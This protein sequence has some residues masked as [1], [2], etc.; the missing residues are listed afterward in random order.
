MPTADAAERRGV[1]RF[2]FTQGAHHGQ[3]DIHPE[4]PHRD[5]Q[6]RRKGFRTSA[7]NAKDPELKELFRKRAEDCARG[8]LGTAIAG[9]RHW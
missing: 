9:R 8:A 3:H 1:S 2:T 7:D 4:Q 6:G 5:L